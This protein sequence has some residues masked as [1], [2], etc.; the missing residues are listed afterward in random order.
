MHLLG[1]V[2]SVIVMLHMAYADVCTVGHVCTATSRLHY[3]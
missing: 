1:L 2:L 3:M